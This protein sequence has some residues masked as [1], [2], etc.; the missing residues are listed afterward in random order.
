[1]KISSQISHNGS[2][3][4][5][6]LEFSFFYKLLQF[7]LGDA[8]IYKKFLESIFK[9]AENRT[10]S[11]LD[12]GCGNGNIVRYLP[13]SIKYLGYDFNSNYIL[14]AKK[15]YSNEKIKF[16]CIDI[17][18]GKLNFDSNFDFVIVIGVLHHLSDEACR[19]VFETAINHLS[20]GGSLLTIDPTFVPKQN[21]IAK[22]IISKDR[23]KSI[24]TSS[25]MKNI[26]SEYFES[27]KHSIYN[28]L[29]NIPYNH[30]FTICK[31]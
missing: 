10:I 21:A 28:N 13:K 16:E 17:N 5:K 29:G 27:I 20:K 7:L 25:Q 12:I 3:I 26:Q 11:I 23:G 22:F 18:I 14:N 24:R 8:K 19:Q 2:G 31:K 15:L 6:I 30:L 1:M 9:E 4:L